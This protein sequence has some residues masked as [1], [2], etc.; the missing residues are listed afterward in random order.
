M[1][2]WYDG[3]IRSLSG[4]RGSCGSRTGGGCAGPGR[5]WGHHHSR[6]RLEDGVEIDAT[7]IGDEAV[8]VHAIGD[9]L[10]RMYVNQPE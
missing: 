8:T 7:E 3:G 6:R 1:I 10:L 5:R 9:K 4:R 2:L